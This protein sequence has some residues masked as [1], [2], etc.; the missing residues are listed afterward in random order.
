MKPADANRAFSC[1]LFDN[2]LTPAIPRSTTDYRFDA[3]A[4]VNP[5]E[6]VVWVPKG[7]GGPALPLYSYHSSVRSP[8]TRANSRLFRVTSTK[9]RASAIEAISKSCAPI[10]VPARSSAARTN[11]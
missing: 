4:F 1:V 2:H 10:G 5:A 9:S 3:E 6:V 11:P 7:H 8:G